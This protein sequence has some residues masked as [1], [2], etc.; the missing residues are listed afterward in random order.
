MKTPGYMVTGCMETPE[1]NER[2]GFISAID[3]MIQYLPKKHKLKNVAVLRADEPPRMGGNHIGKIGWVFGITGDDG[4]WFEE[5]CFTFTIE[6]PKFRID[7]EAVY[8]EVNEFCDKFLV[9]VERAGKLS[10]LG[11]DGDEENE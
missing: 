11:F 1:Y 2:V 8:K 4:M 10:P 3:G 5:T 9:Y 6:A 7:R